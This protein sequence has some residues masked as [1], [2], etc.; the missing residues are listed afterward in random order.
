LC[1]LL[2]S[3]A[4]LIQKTDRPNRNRNDADS[5]AETST[6]DDPAHA[7]TD[8]P[9]RNYVC[10]YRVA[11][12]VASVPASR[13]QKPE[14]RGWYFV[15]LNGPAAQFVGDVQSYVARPTLSYIKGDD[16]DRVY[17]LPFE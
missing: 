14:N 4:K 3:V 9:E 11:H 15:V 6:G 5:D 1:P 2:R 8:Y 10:Q 12:G 7:S 13:L 17:V 16:A